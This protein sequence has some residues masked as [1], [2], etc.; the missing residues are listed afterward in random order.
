MVLFYCALWWWGWCVG[1]GCGWGVG[2][3]VT[4]CSGLVV[5]GVG[6]GG[7]GGLRGWGFC[8]GLGCS[9]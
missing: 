6:F 4:F 2:W 3:L 5:S 9:W 7:W 1:R 8:G